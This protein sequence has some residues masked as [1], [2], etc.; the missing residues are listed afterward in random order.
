MEFKVITISLANHI[1]GQLQERCNK[2]GQKPTDVIRQAVFEF[3]NMPE[4]KC[5][6]SD[7]DVE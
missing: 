2:T 4:C 6:E 7:I 3:L 5:K 1:V